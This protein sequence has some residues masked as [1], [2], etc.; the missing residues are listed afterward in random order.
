MEL[1]TDHRRHPDS[2]QQVPYRPEIG[3]V[4]RLGKGS[5]RW[6]IVAGDG[7]HHLTLESDSTHRSAASPKR[8][9]RTV[10]ARRVRPFDEGTE[11]VRPDRHRST[12][13]TGTAAT[14]A[15]ARPLVISPDSIRQVAAMSVYD[16]HDVTTS[17]SAGRYEARCTCGWVSLD[18]YGEQHAAYK[19]GSA[20]VD[21]ELDNALSGLSGGVR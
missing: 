18:A 1:T 9:R 4:V 10:D 3:D 16:N 11:T 12:P 2:A 7:P 17:P 13:G 8:Q 19:A 20:H 21:A 6:T 15:P 5:V 14:V